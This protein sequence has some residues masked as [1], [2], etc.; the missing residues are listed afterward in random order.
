MTFIDIHCHLDFYSEEQVKKIVQRA[1]K[2]DVG[3][4][5]CN[6]VKPESNRKVL[7]LAG[8]YPEIR[9]ALGLYPTDALALS[10]EEIDSELDF[11]R[12]NSEKI[13]AIGEVGLD[14]KETEDKERQVGIFE[15]IIDLAL[16]LDKALI[17]HSRKAEKEVIDLLEKKK[18]KKVVMHCFS[19]NFKLVQRIVENGWM[20]TIPTNVRNSEHFQK[21]IERVPLENLLCETDSPFLHPDKKENNEPANVVVSYEKIAEIKGLKMGEVER[22]IEGNFEKLV[23]S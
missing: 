8:K 13:I 2:K 12:K 11:I 10:D 3:I 9:A 7:E 15:K 23:G 4:I 1:R 5:V 21:V 19:G 16:E 6:G 14:F 18:A 22:K 20:M 17:V